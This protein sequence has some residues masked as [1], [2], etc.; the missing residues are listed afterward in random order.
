M[1]FSLFFFFFFFE[2]NIFI[3]FDF[4]LLHFK[5]VVTNALRFQLPPTLL[6][7][8]IYLFLNIHGKCGSFIRAHKKVESMSATVEASKKKIKK[9]KSHGKY[10]TIY[11]VFGY[12]LFCWKMKKKNIYIYIYIFQLLFIHKITVHWHVCTIHGTW[13]MQQA[14]NL[15]KKDGTRRH[16]PQKCN[17][18]I[19]LG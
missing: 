12:R 5:W 1:V 8:V 18:N 2:M 3:D 17:P 13:T 11:Y 14:L 16:V 6:D 15:K 7:F 9:I 4:V 10:L 19:A